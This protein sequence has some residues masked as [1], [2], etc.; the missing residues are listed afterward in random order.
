MIQNT[1]KRIQRPVRRQTINRSKMASRKAIYES[2][3]K[4]VMPQIEAILNEQ[5]LDEGWF[6]GSAKK[7]EQELTAE[8]INSASKEELAKTIGEL[9]NWWCAKAGDSVDKACTTSTQYI[10]GLIKGSGEKSADFSK[11]LLMS[12]VDAVRMVVKGAGELVVD[13]V[14]GTGRIILLS[15]ATLFKLAVSGV[16]MA[17]AAAKAIYK[18]VSEWLS[19]TYDSLKDKVQ[20][21]AEAV[22]DSLALFL[23]VSLAVCVLCANKIQG[24]AEAF[25]SF[26]KK[27][28]G[29][30]KE[31]V[32]LAVVATRTWFAVKAKEVAEWVKSVAGDIRS[33]CVEAWNKLEK[34]T[35]KV[36]KAVSGKILDW[37]NS[38]RMTVAEIG[39]KISDTI[40]ATGEH[41][42][43]A[44]DKAVV[45]GIG[46]AV[47][48]LSK[49]YSEDDVVN[50]VRAAYN[51]DLHF[52]AAGNTLI[53][54]SYYA[55]TFLRRI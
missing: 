48:M 16:K 28:A 17:E 38:I 19:S 7:P 40:S 30:V 12:F 55:N 18:T 34:G 42:V 29:D 22:K 4:Q 49:K 45:A 25:G 27:V 3:V 32:V 39:K 21:G 51:E 31:K 5:E 50:I 2:V 1:N 8:Y 9:L 23:K 44:K 26:I 35:I 10:V 46:K 43:A 13:G 47:R 20:K 14:K 36:W 37:C 15:V 54:E 11:K 52:D 6:G 24:A 33:A 41:I 53:N